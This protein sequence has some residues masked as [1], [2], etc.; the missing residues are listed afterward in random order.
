M[1]EVVEILRFEVSGLVEIW[2]AIIYLGSTHAE[3]VTHLLE[4]WCDI[5][6]IVRIVP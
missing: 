3:A 4:I 2:C 5:K 1:F 6:Y